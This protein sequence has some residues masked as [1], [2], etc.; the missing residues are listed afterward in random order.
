M[1]DSRWR[2]EATKAGDWEEG[3]R[4]WA[5]DR[6]RWKESTRSSV[7]G[8]SEL[9]DLKASVSWY[10][11][12]IVCSSSSF[13]PH[14][15]PHSTVPSV[16]IGHLSSPSPSV[17]WYKEAC[18][19]RDEEEREEDEREER[20]EREEG[21]ERRRIWRGRGRGTRR[22]RRREVKKPHCPEEDQTPST[23]L[24]ASPRDPSLPSVSMMI[25]GN[26]DPLD[27]SNISALSLSLPITT[28]PCL[29]ATTLLSSL[30]GV[31]GDEEDSEGREKRE[32]GREKREEEEE[33]RSRSQ[34]GL[35]LK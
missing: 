13:L 7:E 2:M 31:D 32:E 27:T 29:K 22:K 18:D 11:R 21:S 34:R 23:P 14:C 17:I 30:L 25:S 15:L 20:E 4:W 33:E 8:C 6:M 28:R 12:F 35:D 9:R 19:E 26:E 16:P 3:R 10:S 24:T 1:E 5:R